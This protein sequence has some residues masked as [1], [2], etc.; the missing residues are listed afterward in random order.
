MKRLFALLPLLCLVACTITKR[1]FGPGYHVEWKKSPTK[2]QNEPDDFNIADANQEHSIT[3]VDNEIGIEEVIPTDPTK[4][5]IE[6][7]PLNN[8]KIPIEDKT[9]VLEIQSE[10]SNDSIQSDPTSNDEEL[11]EEQKRIVEPFTWISL[12]GLVLTIIFAIL[13]LTMSPMTIIWILAAVHN[14]IFVIGSMISVVHIRR[15]PSH[16][17]G[18]GLT[19][20]LFGLG[21]ATIAG[22]LSFT[23]YKAV[24]LFSK[25]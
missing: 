16:Y 6:T 3:S 20:A 24:E 11:R 23:I 2:T 17:K 21:L 5:V 14:F 19:W 4:E 22:T 1:H 7:I 9:T 10:R 25:M 8:L 15:N 12:G 13:I 18:K